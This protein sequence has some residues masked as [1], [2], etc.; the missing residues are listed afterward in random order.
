M[1]GPHEQ[2]TMRAPG[3]YRGYRGLADSVVRRRERER[4]AAERALEKE[5]AAAGDEAARL[6]ALRTKWV[7]LAS[8]RSRRALSILAALDLLHRLTHADL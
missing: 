1:P 7:K 5:K 3:E 6:R 2:A 8:Q 4:K